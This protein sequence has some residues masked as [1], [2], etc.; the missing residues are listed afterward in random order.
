V[1]IGAIKIRDGMEMN[2]KTKIN[3][4]TCA[5]TP[6]LTFRKSYLKTIPLRTNAIILAINLRFTC[7]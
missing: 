5:G 6:D 2:V 1:L 4:I 7:T 3:T